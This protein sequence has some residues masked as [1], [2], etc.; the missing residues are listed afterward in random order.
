[1]LRAPLS[2]W[3]DVIGTTFI[4][5]LWFTGIIL[6]GLLASAFLYRSRWPSV[7][8]TALLAAYVGFQYVERTKA[9]EFGEQYARAK[10]LSGARVRSEEHTSELQSPMYLVCRLL[11]EKKK[12]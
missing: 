10:G 1:M 8:A 4:I 2:D 7:A 12:S 3:R 9:I 5:D 6:A 11:L